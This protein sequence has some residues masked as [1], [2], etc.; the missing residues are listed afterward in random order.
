M[1][2]IKPW[3]ECATGVLGESKHGDSW[4]SR[5]CSCPCSCQFAGQS[6]PPLSDKLEKSC[7]QKEDKPC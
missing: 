5:D 1:K 3:T 6:G 7:R 2:E 4:L